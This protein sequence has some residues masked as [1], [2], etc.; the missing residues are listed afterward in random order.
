MPA[1]LSH[2]VTIDVSYS[3][4]DDPEALR[5]IKNYNSSARVVVVLCDP[6]SR[7]VT[8]FREQPLLNPQTETHKH[9]E[10]DKHVNTDKGEVL[11]TNQS[12]KDKPVKTTTKKKGKLKILSNTATKPKRTLKSINMKP[13][14]IFNSRDFKS[15]LTTK[16]K[17]KKKTSFNKDILSR[18]GNYLSLFVNLFRIFPRRRVLVVEKNRFYKQPAQSLSVLHK[19]LNVH[20]AGEEGHQT[21]GGGGFCFTLT[22]GR[23]KCVQDLAQEALIQLKSDDPIFTRK[24]AVF[25]NQT[26]RKLFKFLKDEFDWL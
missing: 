23:Q 25:Y 3:A 4:I 16:S 18:W 10:I 22:P 5:R 2:H 26:N 19:F 9:I 12:L 24:L 8:R 11:I 20:Q 1:S 7:L 14:G 6:I 21:D 15:W 13:S 17:G